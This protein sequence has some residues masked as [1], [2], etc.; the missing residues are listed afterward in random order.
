MNTRPA[1]VAGA[2]YPARS[3]ALRTTIAEAYRAAPATAALPA[4]RPRALIV[5]H[6]GYVYSGA[7]AASAYRLLE[8]FA[9]AIRRVVLLGPAHRVAFAGMAVP[10]A[11]C[12]ATPLGEIRIDVKARRT[13]LALPGV[14]ESDQPHAQEHSLEVQ[15]PFL[16]S[17]LGDFSLLPVV[18]GEAPPALVAPLLEAFCDDPET[19]LVISSDLSHFHPYDE[20]RRVDGDTLAKILALKGG[21]LGEQACGARPINGLLRVAAARGWQ[22]HLIAHCN[23]GDTAGDRQR[24]V[25]Y[26]SIGFYDDDRAR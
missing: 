5:P 15:L 9:A 8:P 25:G 18:I 26:A 23:S 7:I 4:S 17:L 19:L 6:A 1:A 12:F 3:A 22:A 13:A 20:A 10:Q 21:L 2:F 14:I 16:Q 11:E 24:V